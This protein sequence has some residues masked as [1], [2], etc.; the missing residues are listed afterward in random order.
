[1]SEK[2]PL[3]VIVKKLVNRPHFDFKLVTPEQMIEHRKMLDRLQI[4]DTDIKEENFLGGLLVDLSATHVL[5][6]LMRPESFN[7]RNQRPILKE[8]IL[9][10]HGIFSDIIQPPTT[11]VDQ[12]WAKFLQTF[13]TNPSLLSCAAYKHRMANMIVKII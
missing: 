3:K 8:V 11:H 9:R 2:E 13:R 5:S 10:H 12:E 7:I 4:Y 6:D 1:M